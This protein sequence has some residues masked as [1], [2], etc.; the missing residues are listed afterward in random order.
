[1]GH[2]KRIISILCGLFFVVGCG[3]QYLGT[4]DNPPDLSDIWTKSNFN[5]DEW[6]RDKA[7]CQAAY[8]D[9]YRRVESTLQESKTARELCFLKKGYEF[10]DHNPFRK[11]TMF[12]T[13]YCKAINPNGPACKSI[14]R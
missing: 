3:L 11:N 4:P 7:E 13:R 2:M 8:D 9:I 14:G 1:M 12:G 5:K 10:S 6:A